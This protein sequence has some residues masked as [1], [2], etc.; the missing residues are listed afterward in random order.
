MKDEAAAANIVVE[1]KKRGRKANDKYLECAEKELE[2]LKGDYK[3]KKADMK[4][5]DRAKARN[6]ISALESRIKKRQKQDELNSELNQL[7]KKCTELAS[8]LNQTIEG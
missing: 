8:I 1:K 4:V 6:R 3:S 7:R 5:K 2:R